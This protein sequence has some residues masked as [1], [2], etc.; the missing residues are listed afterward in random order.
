MSTTVFDIP[1]I[2]HA[3]AGTRPGSDPP[4]E[5]AVVQPLCAQCMVHP[6]HHKGQPI[7]GSSLARFIGWTQNYREISSTHVDTLDPAYDSISILTCNGEWLFSN[8]RAVRTA[9][10]RVPPTSRLHN[11]LCYFIQAHPKLH[12][13]DVMIRTIQPTTLDLW[14]EIFG[15]QEQP[16]HVKFTSLTPWS[17][18]SIQRVLFAC[19]WVRTLVLVFEWNQRSL[20][21]ED[22]PVIMASMKQLQPWS[23]S[24]KHSSGARNSA[25]S[26]HAWNR[27]LSS[28]YSHDL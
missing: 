15:S 24:R 19:T 8:P 13:I 10:S 7:P 6:Q 28:R 3:V 5:Q 26:A 14:V 12:T 25:W 18:L 11:Y 16:R 17:S 4:C 27:L 9:W 23:R 21:N 2:V 20:N 22:R 1:H